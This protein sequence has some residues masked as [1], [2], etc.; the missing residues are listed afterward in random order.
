MILERA[1]LDLLA[2]ARGIH[3]A[4]WTLIE[5]QTTIDDLEHQSEELFWASEELFAST[6]SCPWRWWL[7]CRRSCRCPRIQFS[8]A[9]GHSS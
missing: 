1:R 3:G 8:S 5:R 4:F 7:W 2:A 9:R 6:R